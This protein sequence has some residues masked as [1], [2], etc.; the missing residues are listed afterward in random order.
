M[1]RIQPIPIDNND[2]KDGAEL[3]DNIK[4]VRKAL[5]FQANPLICQN[6]MAGGADGQKFGNAFNDRQKRYFDKVDDD[7]HAS[8]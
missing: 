3:N 7:V 6:K 4:C 2:R 5:R 8:S 1:P